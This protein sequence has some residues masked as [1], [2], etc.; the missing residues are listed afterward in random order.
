MLLIKNVT[1][2]GRKQVDRCI[3]LT[4]EIAVISLD[5]EPEHLIYKWPQVRFIKIAFIFDL[6][7]PFLSIAVV[8]T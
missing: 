7:K 8:S 6:L 2:Y 4:A 5:E 3:I 1:L